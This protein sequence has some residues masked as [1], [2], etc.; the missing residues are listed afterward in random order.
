MLANPPKRRGPR[1][2]VGPW[3]WVARGP[4]RGDGRERRPWRA[5][6]LPRILHHQ[7][8]NVPEDFPGNTFIEPGTSL[9]PGTIEKLQKFVGSDLAKEALPCLGNNALALVLLQGRTRRNSGAEQARE[10][11]SEQ[12]RNVQRDPS[13][14]RKTFG[15]LQD[16]L[17]A[18]RNRF[19][20]LP[21]E[22]RAA[23]FHRNVEE[24]LKLFVREPPL[25]KIFHLLFDALL[26]IPVV[27][28]VEVVEERFGFQRRLARVGE[29]L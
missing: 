3:A 7:H 27:T 6:R 18:L 29:A 16:I 21:V 9:A 11:A 19:R 2:M 26:H 20:T 17:E 4:C 5:H 14:A 1:A 15:C 10:F 25:K 24:G 13:D 22:S 8:L 12:Y 23:I 28:V